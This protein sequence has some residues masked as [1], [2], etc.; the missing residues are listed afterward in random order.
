MIH[1][2]CKL[3]DHFLNVSVHPILETDRGQLSDRNRLTSRQSRSSFRP[4]TLATKH[5]YAEG[6]GT[7]VDEESLAA[8]PTTH[9]GALSPIASRSSSTTYAPKSSPSTGALSTTQS[10]LDSDYPRMYDRGGS[11]KYLSDIDDRLRTINA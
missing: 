10:Y 1:Y 8:G 9:G 3:P 7:S 6:S 4:R 2:H 5:A 11:L